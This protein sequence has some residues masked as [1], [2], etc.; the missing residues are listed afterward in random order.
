MTSTGP[1]ISS[2]DAALQQAAGLFNSGRYAELEER[3]RSL[4]EEYPD[5]GFAWKVLGVS[6]QTQ[7][8]DA[9]P[10]LRKAAELLPDD[11]AAHSNLGNAL[12]ELACLDEAV[13]SC[14]QAIEIDSDYVMGHNNL[15]AALKDYGKTDEAAV[16]CRRALILKPDFAEALSNLGYVLKD[17]G[18]LD[19]AA[20]CFHRALVVRPD[21]AEAHNNLGNVR[22]ELGQFDRAV[23]S[24]RSAL[25]IKPDYVMPRFS[26]VSTKK[27]REGDGDFEA[28][29]TL[30]DKLESRNIS[31][32]ANESICLHFG[33]GK[34]YD[35]QEDYDRA[36]S[37]F[38][39]GCRLNRSTFTYDPQEDTKMFDQIMRVFDKNLKAQLEGGGDES[40]VPIFVLGMPRSGTTLTEQ[41]IASHPD[42]YG[43]GELP[44]I[45][46]IARRDIG[47]IPSPESWK[48][49]DQKRLSAWGSEYVRALRQHSPESRRIT[50]K[51]P[52]NFLALGLIHLMAPNAKIIHVK[53]NPVDTCLSCFTKAF[54]NK[55]VKFSY[56]LAELGQYYVNYSRLMEHWAQV[57]PPGTF[58]DVQYEDIVT[59]QETQARRLIEYCGLEWDSVC[60]DFH[61]NERSVRT[62]SVAQVRK[63]VYN[64]SVER[65]RRYERHLIPLLD[66]LGDLVPNR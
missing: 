8:K 56:D 47:G 1:A 41:I 52:Q 42:V 51:M 37:H 16:C 4:I 32:T 43:A 34:G 11:A 14:R 25:A 27:V 12:R 57:L 59:D 18:Q 61:K 45:L 64:S 44:N 55:N 58:M 6:L 54:S 66:A 26:L 15:G 38:A 39:K 29:V 50:D 19:A 46:A 33:L 53:R 35:D 62:A 49:L 22:K 30:A 17:L 21:Y 13:A 40:H 65:W 48:L 20:T 63:P 31:L 28:L 10:A 7:G 60:L 2:L 23:A 9:L 36:F 24:Y 5:S 3:M